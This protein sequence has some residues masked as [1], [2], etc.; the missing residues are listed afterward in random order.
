MIMNIK[1]KFN[2]L[3]GPVKVIIYSGVSLLLGQVVTDLAQVQAWW[4]V[5][6]TMFVTMGINLIAYLLLQE[7]AQG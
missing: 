6:I 2:S 5:Y 4:S 3:P 1:T 7:K